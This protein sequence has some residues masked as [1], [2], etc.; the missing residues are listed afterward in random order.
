MKC[1]NCGAE[2]K[3]SLLYCENCG[4]D[5]HIVPDFEPELERNIKQSLE[6]IL[7]DVAQEDGQKDAQAGKNAAKEDSGARRDRPGRRLRPL[8]GWIGMGV[9]VL[10]LIAGGVMTVLYFS[11]DY[12]AQRAR[13]CTEAGQYERAIRYYTRAMELDRFNVDLKLELA[14]VYF[15]KSDKEEYEYWLKEIVEDVNADVEQLESAYGK[16]IAI[17]RAREDYQTISDMLLTCE[18]ESIRTTYQNYLAEAP[19][20]SVTAGEYDEVKALKLT[21]TGKGTIYYTLNGSIPDESCEQYTAPILLENGSYTVK[22]V[23]V[24][25]NGV[26]SEIAEAKYRITVEELEAPEL[27]VDDGEYD[28]PVF[29]TVMNDA[30]EIYYTTDGSNPTMD[31]AQYTGPIPMPLGVSHF[32]FARLEVGRSSEI[33]E[34]SFTFELDTDTTPEQAVD[35]VRENALASG[36]IWDHSGHFDDTKAHY[37]YQYLCVANID[38]IGDSKLGDTGGSGT[39]YV[40]AEI[41]VDEQGTAARTGNY[42]AVNVYTGS[43]FRLQIENGIYTLIGI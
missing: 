13:R 32:K 18:H 20:F 31:S 30:E 28:T 33:V 35:L 25:E 7:E 40:V 19:Q 29:I 10:L 4:E 15:L 39:Y 36:K 23:F 1:P 8:A 21:V 34:R 37:Q 6:H 17:Y 27:N 26:A 2:M 5:I 43:F 38:E 3:E 9:L 11:S 22:A 41:L 24:N 12:Q 42:Y 16:L 14:E